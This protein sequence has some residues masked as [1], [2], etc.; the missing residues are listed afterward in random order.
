MDTNTTN[1]NTSNTKTTP[2]GFILSINAEGKP[3]LMNMGVAVW[4]VMIIDPAKGFKAPYPIYRGSARIEGNTDASLYEA[5]VTRG[6]QPCVLRCLGIKLIEKATGQ[7]KNFVPKDGLYV[8]CVVRYSEA[9]NP[10]IR[11]ITKQADPTFTERFGWNRQPIKAEGATDKE[12]FSFAAK[13]VNDTKRVT[14][15]EESPRTQ[16]AELIEQ[17]PFAA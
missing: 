2:Q 5:F 14:V 9:G 6:F 15:Q 10:E 11:V 7:A 8:C 12:R 3:F 16:A 13:L 4:P 17:D 1:N